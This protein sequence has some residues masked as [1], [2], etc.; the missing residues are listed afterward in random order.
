MELLDY[1]TPAGF[2]PRLEC[3]D[4][5]D[6]IDRLVQVL[7]AAGAVGD[8]AGLTAEI[9]RRE[10]ETSTAIGGGLA[11]PHARFPAVKTLRLA[12]ATL[13]PPLEIPA[14]DDQPVDV[15]VLIVGPVGDSRL[16]LRVLARLARLVHQGRFL[17]DL[18]RAATPAQMAAA[19][20]GA[21]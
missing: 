15:V 17:A 10:Q 8:P 11:V 9:R 6:V 12:A 5:D 7:V 4:L 18:R 2:L 21:G 16:M 13:A 19:F 14:A 20:R 1:T 3:K